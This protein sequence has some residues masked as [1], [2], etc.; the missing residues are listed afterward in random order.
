M[1]ILKESNAE[2]RKKESGVPLYFIAGAVLR[3]GDELKGSKMEL[4]KSKVT[5]FVCSTILAIGLAACSSGAQEP[6][7]TEAPV[8]EEETVVSTEPAVET[9][10]V[11]VMTEKSR[12]MDYLPDLKPETI[13][14]DGFEFDDQGR[15]V[16]EHELWDDS[17]VWD[18]TITFEYS[19]DGTL[20][21]KTESITDAKHR[22]GYQL[23]S[24]YNEH[25]DLISVES[26]G[27]EDAKGKST[28]DHRPGTTF[29]Y[30]YDDDGKLIEGSR[31]SGD[32]TPTVTKYTY[33]N[34]GVLVSYW[35][36][37]S[38]GDGY[39]TTCSY[40]ENG[41]LIREDVVDES[42][43]DH[44][45]VSYTYEAMSVEVEVES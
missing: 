32:N 38:K 28:W 21:K 35:E 25:G 10:T 39:T 40:D 30:T 5:A 22:D 34:D 12:V 14:Y 33:D 4:K 15:L 37:S 9:R 13:Y 16:S 24:T 20:A 31:S 43:G 26:T 27:D 17:A 42:D 45:H 29:D 1:E 23:I 18:N 3:Y 41:N 6:T 44:W 11:Y 2:L 19:D 36:S 7:T 8:E